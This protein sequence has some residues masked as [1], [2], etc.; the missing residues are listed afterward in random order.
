MIPD[1][2]PLPKAAVG[3]SKLFPG[4]RFG[5]IFWLSWAREGPTAN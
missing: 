5:Y 4:T 2:Q 1:S 3:E